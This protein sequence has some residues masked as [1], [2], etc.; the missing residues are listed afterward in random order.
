MIPIFDADDVRLA[1]TYN[2]I[3]LND[4]D[5]VY[6][7]TTQAPEGYALDAV[8]SQTAIDY[9]RENLATR[10]GLE[11][12]DFHKVGRVITLRGRAFDPT[13]SGL[14]DKAQALAA[15]FDPDTIA[16]ENTDP[17]LA[18][19]YSVPT[20]DTT[21]FSDGLR[22]SRVYAQVIEMPEP[23]SIPTRDGRV[24][25]FSI[26]LLLKDP[27][28][29]SQSTDSLT[30]GGT[31]SNIGNFRSPA[32]V[33]VVM[34]GAGSGSFTITDTATTNTTSLVMDLS[35]FSSGTVVANAADRTIKRN[36]TTNMGIYVSGDWFEIEPGD[37]VIA[38]NNTANTSSRVT[39]YRPAWS[40]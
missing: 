33:T 13:A 4:P 20:E 23:R 37:N 35:G 15:A 29:Y 10:P 9:I 16:Y 7:S 1:I 2:G 38:Y 24:L 27:R 14:W 18:L 3:T 8:T 11:A 39:S 31:I 19:D 21:N 17:F 30:S 6:E 36:G 28:S 5:D 12:Y 32:T 26:T 22:P 40:L 34:S 25:P